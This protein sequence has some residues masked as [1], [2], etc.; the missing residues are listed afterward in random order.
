VRERVHGH[1]PDLEQGVLDNVL[2]ENGGVYLAQL[3][4]EV[5]HRRVGHKDEPLALQRATARKSENMESE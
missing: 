1:A 3:F 2:D 5:S 4:L